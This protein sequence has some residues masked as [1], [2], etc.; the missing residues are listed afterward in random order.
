MGRSPDATGGGGCCIIINKLFLLKYNAKYELL[1]RY[2]IRTY[3]FPFNGRV[4][5]DT[6]PV[7][8]LYFI[9]AMYIVHV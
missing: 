3:I 4:S 6:I 7:K 5:E 1:S 9:K 2:R 8:Y